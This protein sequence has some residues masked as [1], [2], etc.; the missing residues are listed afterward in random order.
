[1]DRPNVIMEHLLKEDRLLKLLKGYEDKM[2]KIWSSPMVPQLLDDLSEAGADPDTILFGLVIFA[3][4]AVASFKK[5]FKGAHQRLSNL[6]DRFERVSNEVEALVSDPLSHS[7]FWKAILFESNPDFAATEKRCGGASLLCK[8]LRVIVNFLRAEAKEFQTMGRDYE[9]F[10]Q[11][12]GL[13][14]VLKYVKNATGQFHDERMADL[15]Q[16][17]H[18]AL[19]VKANFSAEQ[20]RKL[21]QR[22]FPDVVRK[23][24]ISPLYGTFLTMP[25]RELDKSGGEK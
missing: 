14:P 18:D 5:Q 1:M 3:P 2:Q 10:R 12:D 20:L 21:R 24:R 16:A 19:G 25:L 7:L 6:A 9:H 23:R 11:I 8:R 13:G 4:D 22:K 17:A 15:L